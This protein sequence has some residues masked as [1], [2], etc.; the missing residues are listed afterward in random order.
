MSAFFGIVRTRVAYV[1]LAHTSI[2]LMQFIHYY[3]QCIFLLSPDF[4]LDDN[5]SNKTDNDNKQKP[6]FISSDLASLP[7][8]TTTQAD[9]AKGI[10]IDT[11]MDRVI[12]GMET[13]QSVKVR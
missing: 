6:N 3:L 1:P 2:T 5:G 4:A 8:P 10:T 12:G 7:S 9:F 13:N 11:F